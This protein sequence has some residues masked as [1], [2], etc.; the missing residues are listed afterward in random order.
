MLVLSQLLMS[1]EVSHSLAALF[2]ISWSLPNSKATADDIY[3]LG[4]PTIPFLQQLQQHKE[5]LPLSLQQQT[6]FFQK[7]LPLTFQ[8]ILSQQTNNN[9]S[10]ADLLLFEHAS[11]FFGFSLNHRFVYRHI[12]KNGGT[13]VFQELTRQNQKNAESHRI[14]AHQ[15]GNR[16][17]IIAT[18]RDPIDHFLSGYA[19]C[20][21]RNQEVL[22]GLNLNFTT[23]SHQEIVQL[24]NKRILD[25]LALVNGKDPICR[26]PGRFRMACSCRSHSFSQASFL[27]QGQ[28]ANASIHP[29]LRMVGHLHELPHLLDVVANFSISNVTS[30]NNA[31]ADNG[32]SLFLRRKDWL[33]SS[34]I[35]SICR[36]VYLD[37]LLFDFEVPEACQIENIH[38]SSDDSDDPYSMIPLPLV[39][40]N[41]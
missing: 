20:G 15:V 38:N 10:L 17:I 5:T 1:V 37:Y 29:A 31:T 2:A 21:K 28:G 7:S 35:Q 14:E 24:Y 41:E 4:A 27:I 13:T 19:E 26:K 39:L 11:Y 16:S 23:A 40:P 9:K 36:F 22:Q 18:V 32:K 34:T 25:W 12:Y 30:G 8:W 3:L 6:H 33:Y